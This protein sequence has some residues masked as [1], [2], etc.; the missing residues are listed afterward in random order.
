MI[1][2]CN[3]LHR[4][5]VFQVSPHYMWNIS[6]REWEPQVVRHQTCVSMASTVQA[7]CWICTESFFLSKN[8][9]FLSNFIYNFNNTYTTYA[10]MT[11]TFMLTIYLLIIL[12]ILTPLIHAL[13]NNTIL[14]LLRTFIF[15]FILKYS[16]YKRR[17]YLNSLTIAYKFWFPFQLIPTTALILIYKTWDFCSHLLEEIFIFKQRRIKFLLGVISRR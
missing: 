1:C 3:I 4:I 12:F 6:L 7:V 10:P 17:P 11:P 8:I 15:H 16:T 9:Y 14:M 13:L 2:S 5:S